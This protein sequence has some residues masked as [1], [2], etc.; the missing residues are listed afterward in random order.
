[1][2]NERI[3]SLL[4]LREKSPD[5]A[6]LSLGLAMEYEKLGDWEGVARELQAYLDR[7]DDQ[8]NAWGRLGHALRELGRD[9]EAREAY[10]RG[11]EAANRYR[12]PSMAAEFED[13]LED[14]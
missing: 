13:A 6:R 8:G 11:I 14:W 9:D 4:R 7:T 5:D 2:S 12:H 10:V 3:A 1:M